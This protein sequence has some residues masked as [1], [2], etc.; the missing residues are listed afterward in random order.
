MKLHLLYPSLGLRVTT[1]WRVSHVKI[2]CLGPTQVL[3]SKLESIAGQM[4]PDKLFLNRLDLDPAQTSLMTRHLLGLYW[5]K[6]GL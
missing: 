3:H 6:S 2:H 5:A 1:N 4:D